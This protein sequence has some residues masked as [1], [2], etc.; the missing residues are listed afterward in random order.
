MNIVYNTDCLPAMRAYPD[1]HFDLAVVDPPYF[2][3][4]ERRGYYGSSVS[5]QK[6]KRRC[7]HVAEHWQV[8]SEE[9][10]KELERISKKYIIWGCNYYDH[11]FAPGRIVWDKCNGKTTFSDCELAATNCHDSV[12]LF[13]LHSM[14]AASR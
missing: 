4:P 9:Y 7:Y 6:V 5:T 1:K 10:F 8:P 14:L 11:V 2:S 12:R 13:R 3:G